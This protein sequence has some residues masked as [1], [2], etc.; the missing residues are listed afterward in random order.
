MLTIAKI[1]ASSAGALASYFE[2]TAGR[3]DYYETG[4]EPPGRWAGGYA[5][6]LGLIGTLDAGELAKLMQGYH[7][8]T[9]LALVKNAG[10]EH[11]PGWDCTYSAPKPVSAVWAVADRQTQLDI[12]A[13][14]GQAVA[15]ANSYLESQAI[16]A[17][18]GHLGA[19][20]EQVP[21]VLI[22]TYEHSTSRSG[23]PQLHTHSLVFNVAERADG[24]VGGVDLDTR[25][26]MAAGALYRVALA[27]NLRQ[28][29]Y[30]IA[31]DG[32]SFQIVGVPDKLTDYWSSRHNEIHE[33][34]NAAGLSSY[35]QSKKISLETRETKGEINRSESFAQWQA[36][37]LANG[38]GRE[39]VTALQSPYPTA[40]LPTPGEE[41]ILRELTD[42]NSTFTQLQALH[43]VAVEAQGAMSADQARAFVG[44]VLGHREAVHLERDGRQFYTTQEMRAIEK[45]MVARAV[46]MA[47][48]TRHEVSAESLESVTAGRGLS[49]EQEKALRHIT[50]ETGAVAAVEGWAGTGKSFMLDAARS[51]WEKSGHTVIGAALSGRA[52]E[53]LQS[54]SGIPSQTIHRTLDDIRRGD[55]R[56]DPR[57][58]LVVDEAGMVAS[59][60]MASLIDHC[61]Q[62]GAKLVL[63]GDSRQLQPVE[64]GGAFKAIT[65]R[66]GHAEMTDV[67]RQA[68]QADR[69]MARAFREGRAVDALQNLASRDRLHIAGNMRRAG[70]NAV[71][72]WVS[73]IQS[74]KSSAILAA[75]RREVHE[76][77]S[78]ARVAAREAGM[79]RGEDVNIQTAMGCRDFAAGDRVVFTR[80]NRD[81]GVKNGT[82]AI[83]KH[84]DSERI[85]FAV[86]GHHRG[87]PEREFPIKHSTGY[88]HYDHGYC[89]TT[90]K[91]Q[92]QTLDRVRVVA[93][94]MTGRE[95]S[96][97]AASRAREETHVHTSKD[98]VELREIE[99]SDLARDMSHS[100]QKGTS[101]DYH[102]APERDTEHERERGVER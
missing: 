35:E 64:A 2:R 67:R 30:E 45:S 6:R 48:D 56:L 32:D 59:R 21:G 82:T 76:I 95:W 88:T 83:V 53:G 58:V 60:Q 75:S 94:D 44:D 72:A 66:V 17:R 37:G 51:A 57:S 52:A 43:R 68:A 49:V 24:T 91:S 13:A 70:V 40:P 81:L 27:E 62:A 22:A 77:N 47:A 1:S 98:L 99:E 36:E 74:G 80:N 34:M 63:V 84:V 29:G 11:A 14:H 7:P 87:E 16:T 101:L 9:G 3:S 78:V 69:E 42:R 54:S 71:R 19:I 5:E 12:Q 73:D 79:L 90:H 102:V 31:R 28:L 39:Q 25:H 61:R 100:H 10:E 89:L 15:Y 85:V 96:Y 4:G 8:K 50:R 97:V 92:G 26:K 55:L 93:G 41:K 20:R 38:F 18:R 65:T 23:D 33:A 46:G 86:A